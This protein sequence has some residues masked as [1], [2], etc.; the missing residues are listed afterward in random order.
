MKRRAYPVFAVLM[1]LAVTAGAVYLRSLS[2]G[3]NMTQAAKAYLAT[4]TD[5]QK[6]ISLME[7]DTPQR[8]GWHFIP[9][10]ERKGL[11][12]RDMNQ[13]QRNAALELLN[14]ALSQ[15]GYDKAR[16]I[17]ELESILHELEKDRRGGSIR[18]PQRYYYTIFG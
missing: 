8:V 6:A 1:V 3:A 13:A 12:I 18:D 16:T 11:Q 4:L 9:K 17:M 5:E 15:V 2:T 10:A 14:A 7:Y